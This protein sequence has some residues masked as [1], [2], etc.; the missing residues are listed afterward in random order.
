MTSSLAECLSGNKTT[1]AAFLRKEELFPFCCLSPWRSAV[2][3]KVLSRKIL[4]NIRGQE[5]LKSV[6]NVQV[7][8]Y[9]QLLSVE[10]SVFTSMFKYFCFHVNFAENSTL[11]IMYRFMLFA[12]KN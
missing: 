2:I 3:F 1:P 10:V 9:S 12:V 4:K 7:G 8:A 5:V 11:L 6:L